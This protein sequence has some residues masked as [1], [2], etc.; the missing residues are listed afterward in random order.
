AC[1]AR[2]AAAPRLERG[3]WF[4]LSPDRAESDTEDEEDDEEEENKEDA[5]RDYPALKDEAVINIALVNFL[6]AVTLGTGTE[7]WWNPERKAFHASFGTDAN[8]EPVGLEAHVDGHLQELGTGHTHALVE[9]SQAA[10]TGHNPERRPIVSQ[11]RDQIFVTFAGYDANYLRYLGGDPGPVSFLTM[12][13]FGSWDIRNPDHMN[14]F[15]AL[16]VAIA[17]PP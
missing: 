2:V 9:I 7:R 16:V 5:G 3:R 8:G 10:Q 12:H 13:E 4:R 1:W 11:D 15:G 14:F 17:T 6:N